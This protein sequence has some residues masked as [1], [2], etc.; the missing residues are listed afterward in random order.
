MTA[1]GARRTGLLAA[2]FL[3]RVARVPPGARGLAV[4]CLGRTRRLGS[5]Q[6]WHWGSGS[7]LA[8]LPAA[9]VIAGCRLAGR[10]SWL[11]WTERPAGPQVFPSGRA[12]WTAPAGRPSGP[13]YAGLVSGAPGTPGQSARSSWVLTIP[14]PC[15]WTLTSVSRAPAGTAPAATT[16]RATTTAPALRTWAARTALC[17][18]TPALEGPAEVGAGPAGWGRGLQKRG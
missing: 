7:G 12:A 6:R 2:G 1:A 5:G 14:P 9:G 18:G 11:W 13:G 16:W 17:P 8:F 15:R 10:G 4:L 3:G